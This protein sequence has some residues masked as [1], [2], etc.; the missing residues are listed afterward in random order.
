M[1]GH[2]YAFKELHFNKNQLVEQH[3]GG[4]TGYGKQADTSK[5]IEIEIKRQ[6]A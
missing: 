1:T 2:C 3:L 6:K 5:D 4:S